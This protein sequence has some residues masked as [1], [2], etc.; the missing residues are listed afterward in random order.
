MRQATN[1]ENELGGRSKRITFRRR[2]VPHPTW[3]E[4]PR[5]DQNLLGFK[6]F[7]GIGTTQQWMCSARKRARRGI[8]AAMQKYPSLLLTIS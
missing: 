1:R 4:Q 6:Q 3:Q 7:T 5:M 8:A 2:L